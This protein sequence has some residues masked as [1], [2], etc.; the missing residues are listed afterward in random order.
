MITLVNYLL[1]YSA[2]SLTTSPISNYV[3]KKSVTESTSGLQMAPNASWRN[4]FGPD[5]FNHSSFTSDPVQLSETFEKV[6]LQTGTGTGLQ[7]GPQHAHK[8][9]LEELLWILNIRQI[10]PLIHP[11]H[12][13]QGHVLVI[14]FQVI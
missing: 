8:H 5:T 11:I 7:N 9:L 2:S 14:R 10:S 12:F 6:S 3:N 1:L 13:A 4:F